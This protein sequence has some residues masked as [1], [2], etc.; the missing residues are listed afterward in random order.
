M[1]RE[2]ITKVRPKWWILPWL[3][4]LLIL[5][6]GFYSLGYYIAQ[7]SDSAL[8]QRESVLID[9]LGNSKERV[10]NLQRELAEFKVG[11]QVDQTALEKI[12]EQ[13]KQLETEVSDQKDEIAFYR[14]YINPKKRSHTARVRNWAVEKLGESYVF[15]LVLEKNDINE[16]SEDPSLQVTVE[17]L[18]KHKETGQEQVLSWDQ[19]SEEIF[20]PEMNLKF[21]YFKILRES[22]TLPAD[23]EPSMVK[24][25]LKVGRS[26]PIVRE[27]P[28]KVIN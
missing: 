27:F 16:K 6:G 8:T 23:F 28:W 12:N 20:K 17:L 21:T 26:A 24:I 11:S 9:Q 22:F 3:L 10:L 7:H 13:I 25:S 15:R 4:V 5:L 2:K 19:L 1:R 18:G 14:E